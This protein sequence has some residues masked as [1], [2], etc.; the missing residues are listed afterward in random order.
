MLRNIAIISVL[1]VATSCS[2]KKAEVVPAKKIEN[3]IKSAEELAY[4]KAFTEANSLT[5]NHQLLQSMVGS[6]NM[7]VSV[8]AE[9]SADPIR[10]TGH[11]V[12]TAIND[13]RFIKAKSTINLEAKKHESEAILGFDN[14][15]N[16]FIGFSTESGSNQIVNSRGT[17]DEQRKVISF[18]AVTTDPV[19]KIQYRIKSQ[20]RL[21]NS[22]HRILTIWEVFPTGEE[23]KTTEI[24]YKRSKD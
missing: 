8:W 23:A 12:V 22:E 13:G 4:E 6:W 9:P 11:E 15:R 14:F 19:S 20:L 24:E 3:T 2:I 21:N 5:Q 1:A 7:N 16:A 17:I 10:Y 18:M